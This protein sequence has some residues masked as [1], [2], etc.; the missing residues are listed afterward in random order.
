MEFIPS[1]RRRC[2]IG[3]PDEH[4][5]VVKGE[6]REK[7]RAFNKGHIHTHSTRCC[8]HSTVRFRTVVVGKPN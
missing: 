4:V 8:L 3:W 5:V 6:E 7:V 2:R 1:L